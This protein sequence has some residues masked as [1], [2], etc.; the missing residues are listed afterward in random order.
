MTDFSFSTKQIRFMFLIFDTNNLLLFLVT[1]EN[2]P[3]GISFI[4]AALDF[5]VLLAQTT[6]LIKEVELQRT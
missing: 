3:L 2:S 5:H 6:R 4:A 1:H